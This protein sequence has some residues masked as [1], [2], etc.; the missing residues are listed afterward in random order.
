[1]VFVKGISPETNDEIY[2]YDEVSTIMPRR[3]GQRC[4]LMSDAIMFFLN[5]SDRVAMLSERER[6]ELLHTFVAPCMTAVR[7][8]EDYV[9]T[10]L[11]TKEE[12]DK[13]YPAFDID[14]CKEHP[15]FEIKGTLRCRKDIPGV[16]ELKKGER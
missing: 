5:N 9:D 14:K 8:K 11:S 12:F 15:L 3:N 1:M 2:G 4:G 16:K 7:Y 13:L 10:G 6:M